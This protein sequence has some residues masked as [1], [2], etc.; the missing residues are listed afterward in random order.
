M[1]GIEREMSGRR[2]PSPAMPSLSLCRFFLFFRPQTN[3]LVVLRI[4]GHCRDVRVV[5]EQLA[6]E[7]ARG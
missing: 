3:L 1:R 5:A 4:P 7:R 6:D 2:P